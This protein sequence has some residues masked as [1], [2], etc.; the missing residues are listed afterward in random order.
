MRRLTS[1]ANI[2]GKSSNRTK[3]RDTLWVNALRCAD[4]TR[5]DT[6]LL[7]EIEE[8]AHGESK[9]LAGDLRKCIALGRSHGVTRAAGLGG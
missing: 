5:R 8:A 6:A 7:R 9:S 3:L 4:M 2:D 1:P